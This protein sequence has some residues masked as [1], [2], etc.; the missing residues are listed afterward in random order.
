MGLIEN[1]VDLLKSQVGKSL[2]VWGANGEDVTAMSDVEAWVRRKEQRY[3][4]D[5]ATVERNVKRVMKLYAELKA[6]G[7][8][9]IRAFDCSGL[10]YWCLKQLGVV[11]SDLSSRGLYGICNPITAAE[12]R[13]GDLIFCYTD[14][15]GNGR[16]DTSEIYHVGAMVSDVME[17]ECIGRDEGVV[18]LPIRS[19]WKGF[20]RPKVFANIAL[21]PDVPTQ[22][23]DPSVHWRDLMVATPYMKGPDV[24][25]VQISLVALDYSVGACGCD[26]TYGADTEQA[27]ID[28][29]S[30]CGLATTGVVDIVTWSALL[31]AVSE[32]V[33]DTAYYGDADGDGEITAADA[34]KVLRSIV[35]LEG[36]LTLQQGDANNDGAI[37]ASDVAYVLRCVVKLEKPKPIK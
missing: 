9:P 28:F 4:D 11:K 30:D 12:L 23:E 14:K 32:D 22:P 33:T 24:V 5:S 34:A 21:D 29:Q 15:N 18:E 36:A 10:Q 16:L 19:K 1:Y 3:S 17:I 2:Y 37:T 13:A 20:G 8:S 6:K 25:F 27:V 31:T 35:H 7:I 26:S